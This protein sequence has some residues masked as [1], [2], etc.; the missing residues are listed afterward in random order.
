ME[1]EYKISWLKVMGV[2]LAFVVVIAIICFLLPKNK[3]NDSS[4]HLKILL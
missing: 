3:G 1:K 4:V 2:I